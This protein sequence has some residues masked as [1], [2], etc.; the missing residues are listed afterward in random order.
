MIT[1][2]KV[3][4]SLSAVLYV[5]QNWSVTVGAD[6]D[7]AVEPPRPTASPL[8]PMAIA[9][10]ASRRTLIFLHLPC[11]KTVLSCCLRSSRPGHPGFTSAR[12][13]SSPGALGGVQREAEHYVHRV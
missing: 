10:A 1:F 3:D 6:A 13:L 4:A 5:L 11:I 12:S 7:A 9:T 8:A 2:L